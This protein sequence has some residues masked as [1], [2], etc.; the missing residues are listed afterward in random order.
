MDTDYLYYLDREGHG[1]GCCGIQHVSGFE[2]LNEAENKADRKAMIAALD[3]AVDKAFDENHGSA[4]LV[5]IVLTDSQLQQGWLRVIQ[6]RGFKRV[7][8]FRNPNTDNICNVYHQFN[9]D[10]PEYRA[11][12][13]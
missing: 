13:R 3:Y 10:V 5:E 7:S 9:P 8:R 11:K 6:K 4:G 12:K 1:G 2:D